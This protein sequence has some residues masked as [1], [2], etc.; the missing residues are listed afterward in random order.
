MISNTIYS[1]YLSTLNSIAAADYDY[2]DD[3]D[4]DDDTDDD[5]LLN[6]G[7][8]VNFYQWKKPLDQLHKIMLQ[9]IWSVLWFMT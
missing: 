8:G 1:Y 9:N 6:Y 2:D 5:D 4:G 7:M 3:Y